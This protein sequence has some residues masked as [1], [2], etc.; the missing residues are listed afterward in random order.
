MFISKDAQ[1]YDRSYCIPEFFFV[2]FL[3]FELWSILYFTVVNSVG[4]TKNLA[5]FIAKYAV[6]ANPVPTR[7][8]IL[9]YAGSSGAAPVGGKTIHP[10]F[11]KFMLS[12]D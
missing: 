9:K 6:A 5:G 12:R 10:F 4:L 8:S 11:F 1:F 3:V 7:S 2:Q